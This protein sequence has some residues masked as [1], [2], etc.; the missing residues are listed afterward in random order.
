[1]P[2][3][4]KRKD[5][6][7]KK[8]EMEY[9]Y[10]M[11]DMITIN[12]IYIAIM[13]LA[14]IY[15]IAFGV[16]NYKDYGVS[17]ML[18]MVLGIVISGLAV[19]TKIQSNNTHERQHESAMKVAKKLDGWESKVDELQK[20]NIALKERNNELEKKYNQSE[21]R[22][23]QLEVLFK[24]YGNNYGNYKVSGPRAIS[25]QDLT[26]VQSADQMSDLRTIKSGHE[27]NQ[28]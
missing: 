6:M 25:F 11:F 1:M 4:V 14:G 15:F 27:Q 16:L 18:F 20:E 24:K 23:K 10:I 22:T 7:N 12:N 2:D 26:V 8:T 17:M 28:E 3:K 19:V 21:R 5:K 13:A 9:N